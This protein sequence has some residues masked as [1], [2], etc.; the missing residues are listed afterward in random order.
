MSNNEDAAKNPEDV[1]ELGADGRPTKNLDSGTLFSLLL[2][3][4]LLLL[5][6]NKGIERVEMFDNRSNGGLERL[7]HCGGGWEGLARGC[8]VY[9]LVER[10]G[11]VGRSGS[12]EGMSET[13][14]RVELEGETP[15]T[16]FGTCERGSTSEAGRSRDVE[17]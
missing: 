10:F 9:G 11:K 5:E 2:L 6:V 12:G 3:G 16:G 8:C 4:L 17:R 13:V 1:L 14:G 15:L 7:D